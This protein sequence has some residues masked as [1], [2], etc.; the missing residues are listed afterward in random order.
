MILYYS[1]LI[2][3]DCA[4]RLLLEVLLMVLFIV[5]MLF[6]KSIKDLLVHGNTTKPWNLCNEPVV[7]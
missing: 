4:V 3:H 1:K 5:A 6:L 2:A 7:K